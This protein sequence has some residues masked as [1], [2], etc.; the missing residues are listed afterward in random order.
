MTFL[1]ATVAV[2]IL[3]HLLFC[4]MWG[5]LYLERLR[6]LAS[7]CF[8]LLCIC[9][10]LCFGCGK[11]TL[12]GDGVYGTNVWWYQIDGT[13]V[14]SKQTLGEF[15]DWTRANYVLLH[16]NG[17]D[18]VIAA[19]DTIRTNAPVWFASAY[20]ARNSYTNALFSGAS[21]G[22]VNNASNTLFSLVSA[23]QSHART[24]APLTNSLPK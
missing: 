7:L 1:L 6:V 5:D 22:T 24:A 3:L 9:F 8:V 20:A 16:V 18:D 23:I 21:P 14:E 17:R 13:L 15:V 4:A 11:T 12:S 19:A 2:A 10:G